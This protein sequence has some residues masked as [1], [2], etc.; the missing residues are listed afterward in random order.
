MLSSSY[1]SGLLTWL[2]DTV[3]KNGAISEEDFDL[4]RV[5]DEPEEIAEAVNKWYTQHKVTGKKALEQ[6]YRH[7]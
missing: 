6:E 5:F 2:R 1:W 3:L 7:I 4:L